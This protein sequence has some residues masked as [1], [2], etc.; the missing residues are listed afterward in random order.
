MN[1]NLHL[2]LGGA[3]AI[4]GAVINELKKRKVL[5]KAVERSKKVEGIETV[6]ADLSDLIQTKKAIQGAS[7]VYLCAGL[8]YRSDIW[9]KS[10]PKIM[11]NVIQACTEHRA[12]LIFF[13]NVYMYGPPPL[14]IPFDEMSSQNPLTKKGK[15]RKETAD[16]LLAAHN[17]G[18]VKALIGRSADFYGPYAVN[19]SF[20]IKFLENIQKDKAPQV[21]GKPGIKHTYAYTEDNARALVNLALDDSTYGEVWHLPTGNPITIDEVATIFNKNLGKDFK[22]SYMSRILLK[23]LSIFISPLREVGEVLYQFDAPYVMSWEKFKKKFPD[24]KVTPYNE[25]IEKMI[26]SFKSGFT[27]KS[28]L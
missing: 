15:A 11:K 3:G 10:W 5:V 20:Y 6:T 22:V 13:D 18:K 12:R 24:F 26:Q 9:L 1:N 4:G 21:L 23:I 19:S 14:P 27:G 7:Y 17:A 25:G 2:V 28:N 16:L 8:P